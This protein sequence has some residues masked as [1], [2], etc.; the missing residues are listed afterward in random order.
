MGLPLSPL[1]LARASIPLLLTCRLGSRDGGR[2]GDLLLKLKLTRVSTQHTVQL[3]EIDG[4]GAIGV[5]LSE[6]RGHQRSKVRAQSLC[7]ARNIRG[8]R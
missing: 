8:Q 6:V 2:G 1:H 3:V 7:R 4:S 5:H